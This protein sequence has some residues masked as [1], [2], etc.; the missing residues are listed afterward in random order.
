MYFIF[1]HIN[2]SHQHSVIILRPNKELARTMLSCPG[3]KYFSRAILY[4]LCSISLCNQVVLQQCCTDTNLQ[5][6]E[7]IRI[8]D[9]PLVPKL[10]RRK[11]REKHHS[12]WMGKGVRG[13]HRE[14]RGG[15]ETRRVDIF[16]LG[17]TF[18]SYEA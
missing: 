1:I 16:L 15:R 7:K 5:R 8:A 14:E 6:G 18:A 2:W 13:L 9:V 10:E 12:Q 17:M 11:L 4:F 3:G